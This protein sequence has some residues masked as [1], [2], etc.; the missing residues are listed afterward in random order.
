MKK[1]SD[2]VTSNKSKHL[3]VETELKKLKTFNS[4]YFKGKN[5]FQ[6]DSTQNYFVFQPMYKYFKTINSV[7]NI[8]EWKS[9]GLSNESVKTPS[10]SN[11]SL[12]PI[13][14][15]VNTKIRVKFSGSCL[16]QDKVTYNP[17]II[18]NIYTV[19]EISKNYNIRSYPTLKNCLFRAV[20][21]TRHANIDQYKYSGYS[22]GCDR[23]GEISFD[24]RRFCRNVIIFATDMSNSSH[25]N[26]KTNNI[27]VLGK[28]FTQGINGAIT[29]AEKLYPMNFTE[30]NKKVCFSLHYNGANSYLF[31]NGTEI[32]KFKAKGSETV[33]YPL[34]L[35]NIS[36]DFSVDNMKKAGLNG[37]VYDFIV[38]YDAIANDKN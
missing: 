28:D 4:S 29:Y 35:G 33:A 3:L 36:K 8:S 18:I 37:Y 12:N 11:N 15:N 30:N 32:I 7:D 1:N 16:K 6:E 2:R 10:T 31:A 34:C 27:L 17:R 13:L 20:S 26:N 21:L 24:S 38:D 19:Y 23:R 9:K 25:S 22:V 14:D 5:H